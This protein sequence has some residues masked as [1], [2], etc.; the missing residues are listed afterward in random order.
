MAQL[1][2]FLGLATFF[3]GGPCRM[4]SGRYGADVSGLGFSAAQ[5]LVFSLIGSLL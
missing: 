3:R 2:W 5:V 4:I 1:L